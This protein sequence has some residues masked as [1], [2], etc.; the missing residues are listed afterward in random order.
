MPPCRSLSV[1][2]GSNPSHAVVV[3]FVPY[4]VRS[5]MLVRRSRPSYAYDVDRPSACVVIADL[6]ILINVKL[7]ANCG[8]E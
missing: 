4:G 3:V 2:A 1:A 5:V 7:S 8:Q 6:S